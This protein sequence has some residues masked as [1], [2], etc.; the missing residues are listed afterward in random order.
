MFEGEAQK[1]IEK[2]W[3]LQFIYFK[4]FLVFLNPGSSSYDFKLNSMFSEKLRKT[5]ELVAFS[6]P[7]DTDAD[8]RYL[9]VTWK[10]LIIKDFCNI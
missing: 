3:N 1:N 6:E 5:L 7:E 9:L 2:E 8:G 4:G 10:S